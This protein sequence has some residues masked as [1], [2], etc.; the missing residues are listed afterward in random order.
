MET[1]HT[2]P[3][4]D[5]RADPA[6]PARVS[7]RSTPD[8]EEVA[9]LVRLCRAGRIYAVEAWIRGGKPLYA[10]ALVTRG[11]R[12]ESALKIAIH[13]RQ[14]DLAWLLLANGF[15]PDP[16][17]E[18]LL[19]YALNEKA[20]A[21]VD[22]LLA[23]GADPLAVDGYDVIDT[24]EADLYDRFTAFGLDLT[25]DHALAFELARRSSNRPAYG[26]A[27]RHR[28]ETR[29]A[30]ELAI[31][32]CDAVHEDKERAVALLLWA[33]AD[34]HLP[35]PQLRWFKHG[36]PEDPDCDESAVAVAIRCG[37]GK[38]LAKLRPDP[39]RDDLALLWRSVEDVETLDAL[40]AIAPPDDWS[41]T[42]RHAL[43]T[44]TYGFRSTYRI[45]EAVERMF[46]RYGAKLAV[47]D[48]EGIDDLRRSMLRIE[49]DYCLLPLLRYLARPEHCDPSIFAEL[50]RT[51]TMR[52][53]FGGRGIKGVP[54][55]REQRKGRRP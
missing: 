7:A 42:I 12:P 48:K 19:A 21:F 44:I 27:K 39:A 51:P 41:P 22:L 50:M 26:W 1:S 30:R 46:T 15:P 16:P 31:A 45:R 52:R 14:F 2:Y 34:P 28:S 35:V 10:T 54:A 3:F 47:L 29:V 17:H 53:R 40:M 8:H 38:Y 4:I 43:H 32:L 6:P 24:Y 11:R 18:R 9:E 23:W 25:D 55:P 33:G 20:L 37:H 5:P 36:E 49:N 13:T